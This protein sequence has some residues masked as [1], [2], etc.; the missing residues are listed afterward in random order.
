MDISKQFSFTDFLA[1][2]FP[3]SFA[4]LG[5]YLLLMLTPAQSVMTTVSVDIATGIVFLVLSYIVG[6][7]LSGF[8]FPLV[9]RI[10]R[11]TGVKSITGT[12]PNGII[13]DE[14]IK[15][16]RDVF[17]DS[18]KQD[19]EWSIYHY[20]L[21]RSLITERMPAV[22]QRLDRNNNLALFRRN[23]VLPILI[24]MLTGIGWGIWMIN[25]DIRG[26]GLLLISASVVVCV[27]AIRTIVERMRSGEETVVREA[28]NGFV[29]GYRI[30][31]FDRLPKD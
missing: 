1:Y 30:G 29:A 10:K 27:L 8:S 28:L 16:F 23:L 31:L 21:C 15:A 17:G 19:T 4:I 14:V 20:G 24:W 9:N 6:V 13:R 22:A 11:I 3:G 18:E 25:T 12:L 5:I 2:F 7:V 26:W